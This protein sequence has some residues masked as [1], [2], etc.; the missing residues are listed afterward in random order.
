MR[1]HS[2]SVILVVLAGW[3]VT[4][5][6]SAGDQERGHIEGTVVE[7]ETG[8]A[9]PGASVRIREVDRGRATNAEGYF[10]FRDLRP[11]EY[12][13]EVSFV[14]FASTTKTVEVDEAA[15]TEVTVELSEAAREL[16][17]LVV[18]GTARARAMAEVYRPTSVLAGDN[19]D[20]NLGSSVPE[21]LNRV[22]GFAAEY[23][24]PGAS[25]PT[26]RG[27]SGDRVLMLEDGQR[28]GDLYQTASDHGVMVDPLTAERM[29]VIRGPAGLLY[30]ANALGGV[31]NVIRNDIPNNRP[32]RATGTFSSQA[33]SVSE[34]IAGGGRVRAPLGPLAVTAEGTARRSG[35]VSTPEG[36]LNRTQM[37]VI[38]G[39]LGAS[40]FPEWGSVG[41]SYRFYDNVYGVPGEFEG[42]IIPGAH[43]GGVDIEAQRHIGRFQAS[44]D[45]ELLHFFD[46]VEL[47]AN[48]TRYLHDE[49]EQRVDD[50]EDWL[51]ACFDQTTS[52]V[53]VTAHHQHG[54]DEF[55]AEGAAGIS[56][57]GRNLSTG[58]ASPGSRSADS[59]TLSAFGFE[60]FGRAP[61]RFQLGARFDHNSVSPRDKSDINVRTDQERIVKPVEA[62]QFNRL[63]GSFATLYDILDGWTVGASV[64]RSARFPAIEEMYSD[65]PHLADFSFDIGSPDLDPEVG[66]G[67]DL[68]T[69]ANQRGVDLELA[70]YYNRINN[71]IYYRPTGHTVRVLREFNGQTDRRTTPVFE[72]R[73]DD[74]DFL[75]VEGQVEWQPIANLTL[76]TT[77]SF[78]H[79]TRRTEGD[80]LPAISPLS[81]HVEATYELGDFTFTT[82]VDAAAAQN[83][84]PD[85][86]ETNGSAELPEQPTDAYAYLNA[87]VSWETSIGGLPNNITI[88]VNNITNEAWRDH[89][90][91]LKEIAPQPGRNFRLTYRVD[92]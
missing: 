44:Y 85:P 70:L 10:E 52:E 8:E 91:R 15:T 7:M 33:E 37:R 4:T 32:S 45:E 48:L 30:G 65:G 6:V 88:Q 53:N 18:T 64:S 3:F 83:R 9:L 42:E 36:T 79:A 55:R 49:I 67:F 87:G 84:V 61:F 40:Y 47:D 22:P 34:G 63:S 16:E 5:E 38:N 86:V 51:G 41:A 77:G 27:L 35:D 25:R 90:S 78:T 54:R 89:L 75:G 80:P 57:F 12:T 50:G 1:V 26:I 2:F 14:G 28:T 21:T 56:Y 59:Y 73:G 68:F 81:G 92:F 24:G 62:R 82:S 60:E 46:G 39:S 31:V 69:R 23:N 74:A 43:P 66:Y 17:D 19:L 20:R 11:R 71:Y 76:G 58:C 13:L 29:E 72:A